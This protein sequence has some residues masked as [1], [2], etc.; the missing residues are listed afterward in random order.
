MPL[1]IHYD[2]R[3]FRSVSN[4]PSGEVTAATL[5]NCHQV[6]DVVWATYA[7]GPITFGTLAATVDT[8]V[9]TPSGIRMAVPRRNRPKSGFSSAAYQRW[10]ARS[11]VI[12][13][14]P[15]GYRTSLSP[16]GIP[17]PT[18]SCCVRWSG[19]EPSGLYGANHPSRALP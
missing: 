1:S 5:F 15:N 17:W 4:S 9:C 11:D 14:K 12:R 3:T 2:G 19:V 7:G 18:S 10:S 13:C 16:S 8:A 6:G